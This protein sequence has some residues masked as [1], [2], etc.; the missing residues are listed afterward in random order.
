MR[1]KQ[2]LTKK[3]PVGASVKL[4][5]AFDLLYKNNIPSAVFYFVIGV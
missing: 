3:A 5:S 4:K 1:E 2:A